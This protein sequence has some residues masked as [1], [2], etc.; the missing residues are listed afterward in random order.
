MSW[1]SC[2]CVLN[3]LLLQTIAFRDACGSEKGAVKKNTSLRSAGGNSRS[4]PAACKAAS[5]RFEYLE[6][7]GMYASIRFRLRAKAWE[8]V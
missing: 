1:D 4:G 2:L 5:A 8:F 3:S 7:Q 6:V